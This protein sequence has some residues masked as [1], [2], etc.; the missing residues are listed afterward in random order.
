MLIDPS[1]SLL[2]IVDVQDRLA[3]VMDDR[4]RVVRNCAILMKAAAEMD[5]PVVVSEQ[6]P[7]GLGP[8][9]PELRDLACEADIYGKVTFSCLATEAIAA[10]LAAE[11]RSQTIVAGMESHVCV[12]QSAL[13]LQ[14]R[15]GDDDRVFVVADAVESRRPDSKAIALD[16][17]R[18]EGV[19]VVTTEMVVFEWMRTSAIPSFRTLS[20][21]IR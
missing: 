3:R 12:L 18:A 8:T 13:D 1:R 16:R 6:Y 21:L 9:I 19:G 7:Q 17:F 2:L 14:A 20:K 5:V 4:D 11:G 10:R 15:R